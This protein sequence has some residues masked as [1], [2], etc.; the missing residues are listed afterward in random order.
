M[1]IISSGIARA[2]FEEA[3]SYAR[4]RI[5]GGKRLV[6]HQSM[7][8]KLFHMQTKVETTRLIS[9]AA[10]VFNQHTSTPAEEYSL[11]A[12]IHGTEAAFNVTHEAIQVFGGN[13]LTKEYLVEKLFRDARAMLIEDGSNDILAIAGGHTIVKNYPRR[14]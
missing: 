6:D 14:S 12:K 9:R 7:Q 4:N 11:M 3:I 10:Y 5:Q 8:S 13:G 1:G 2:A